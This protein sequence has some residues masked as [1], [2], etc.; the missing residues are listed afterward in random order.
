MNVKKKLPLRVYG[1]DEYP[2]FFR[3]PLP[4]DV[5]RVRYPGF[6]PGEEILKKG[7]I[8]RNGAMPL[9]CDIYLER[10]V[11]I[12]L[13][14]GT[15]IYVDI[16]RPVNHGKYPTLLSWSPYG[17][18]IG[19]QWLDELPERFGVPLA[20][21]SE[22]MK[23]EGP[24]PAFWV[25]A[26]YAVIHPDTRGAYNSG[27]HLTTWGR[28]CAEDGCDVIDW[29]AKQDWS[30]SKV[31]MAGNSWLTVSQW[32]IAAE[33]PSHLAAIAPWE[34]AS[35]I[36]RDDLIR[37]G[38]PN[39]AFPEALFQSFSGMNMLEDLTLM[40]T[41]EQNETLYWSD[42]AARL[43]RI[44]I[45]AYIVAS[46]DNPIHT[47]GTLDAWNR[48]SSKN[49][50]LRIHNTQE[51]PDFYDKKNQAELLKF[52]DRYL[53]GIENDWEKTPQIRISVLD[54][55]RQDEINRLVDNF[56]PADYEHVKLYLCENSSLSFSQMQSAGFS[57]YN[58]E[59]GNTSFEIKFSNEYE[60]IGYTKLRMFVE[61][62]GSEDMDLFVTL[63]KLNEDGEQIIRSTFPGHASPTLFK[64][65]LRVSRRDLDPE[66]S[67]DSDPVLKLQGEKLLSP[68]EIVP[69]DIG[70]WPMAMKFHE[71]EILRLTIRPFT[72]NPIIMPFGMAAIDIPKNSFTF[73][74]GTN[75]EMINLS[76]GG[77]ETMPEWA[78]AQAV[79]PQ[80]R[81]KGEHIIHFGN[82]FD[83]HLL[84]PLK[85]L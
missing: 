51:W 52:F 43:E 11:S 9:P 10:D 17:K 35:D 30:N 46:Y 19:G 13:R 20:A 80:P 62:S 28:Q 5:P 74:P 73:L 67:T 66:R 14:D 81:N 7:T 69:V 77:H 65:Y 34:G 42:K 71:G 53:K 56:P 15:V 31:G 3:Y 16:F 70:I 23:W 58:V 83:S 40:A 24:D 4:L 32:F 1:D 18:Q 72:N 25:N 85:P 79:Y 57:S 47:H 29:I 41:T 39:T 78:L 48:I 33:Q 64:G 55:G 84:I 37:G 6:N 45:P 44:V 27:G 60:L 63:E 50:W 76:G 82:K 12:M 68:G 59:S 26:G 61:A 21:T 36:M 75:P 49:K 54:P 2:V 8:R 38:I 22:L